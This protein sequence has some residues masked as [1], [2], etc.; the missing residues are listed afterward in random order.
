MI[1]S[2]GPRKTDFGLLPAEKRLATD[3]PVQTAGSAEASRPL[4]SLSHIAASSQLAGPMPFD[5]ARVESLARAI[6]AGTYVLDPERTAAA[7]VTSLTHSV[8]KSA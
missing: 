2:I 3:V 4:T 7:M 5:S 8:G 6:Q 1:D